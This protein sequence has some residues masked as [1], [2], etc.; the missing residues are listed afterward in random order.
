MVLE[1]L[2]GRNII[3]GSG[4]P[5]RK[6]LLEGL[7]IPFT[8]QTKNVDES[9]SPNLKREQVARF[10]SE[11][12][13]S[14]FEDEL[15]DK[16]LLITSDTTVYLNGEILNKPQNEAEAIDMLT[17]LS[18]QTHTV[19]TAVTL[20]DNAKQVTFHD[21]TDVTFLPLTEEEIKF[22]I[23]EHKPYDKAGSYGAQEFMGYIAIEK[24]EGSYFNVM[25]LPVHSVWAELKAW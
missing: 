6:A 18:G 25:G 23:N 9:Y 17:K 20:T 10:L 14:A 12:K 11:L 8:V 21:E 24:L 3:L 22:Y 7:H 15:K 5:R 19:I 1:N 16:D 13:A 2:Q 4:S